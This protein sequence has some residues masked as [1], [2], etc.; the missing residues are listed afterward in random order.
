MM[1]G[2]RKGILLQ[3]PETEKEWMTKQQNERKY[4]ARQKKKKAKKKKTEE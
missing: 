3:L 2:P 4:H 1:Q